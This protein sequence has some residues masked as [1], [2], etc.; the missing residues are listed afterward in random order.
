MNLGSSWQTCLQ[1]LPPTGAIRPLAPF[2]AYA[3]YS[4]LRSDL[5]LE[6]LA[7]VAIVATL[8]SVGPRT[9]ELLV[10]LYPAGLTFIL[11]DGMR[12]FQRVGLTSSRV[13]LCDLRSFEA[14]FFGSGGSTFHDYWLTHHSTALDL[15]CAVP[16][17]TFIPWCI[18]GAIY[19]YVKD[20]N[21]M[22]RFMWGF[23]LVNVAG[24]ITYH[25]AP[26]APPWYFHAHGC[27]V[28]L[29]TPASEG[30]A[31]ARVDAVL[32]VPYFRGMYGK[33]SSVFGAL[34]SLHCAYPLLLVLEG[35]RAFGVKLKVLALAYYFAMLFSAVYLDHHW[36][37]DAILGSV[38]AVAIA[39]VVRVVGRARQPA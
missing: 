8:A 28:D 19:L 31:L 26:A 2:I 36:V 15:F 29:A 11:Y 39:L 32:G 14:R 22:R 9:K 18:A 23:L 33:A 27:V 12:P 1:R 20:G 6:H 25:L 21:A 5:R 17:A 38:Y 34:P 7:M 4:S 13:L 30:P 10:G 3:L 35:W 24:F 16:Y 37:L